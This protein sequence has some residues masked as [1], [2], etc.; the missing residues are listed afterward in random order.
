MDG[1]DCIRLDEY[2]E[3]N[4]LEFKEAKGGFPKSFWETYSSFANT[5][6]G[7]IVL[8]AAENDDG[9]IR[10]T[11]IAIPNPLGKIFEQP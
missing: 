9:T 1:F 8:G 11:G 3:N 7:V 2:R 4:R 6:G 5:Q 10:V